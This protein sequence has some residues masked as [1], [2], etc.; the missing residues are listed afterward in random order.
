MV[1]FVQAALTR[2]S[3]GLLRI[4]VASG[5]NRDVEASKTASQESQPLGIEILSFEHI[6]HNYIGRDARVNTGCAT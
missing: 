5:R 1:Y 4:K 6:V 3:L 2:L